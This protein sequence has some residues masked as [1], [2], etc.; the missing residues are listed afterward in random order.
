MTTHLCRSMT[1]LASA[2]SPGT[3]MYFMSA[4]MH[5]VLGYT[6][7]SN[8]NFDLSSYKIAHGDAGI[9]NDSS[10]YEHHLKVTASYSVSD[11]DIGRFVAIKS[12][13]YP[14]YNS[15]LFRV[16]SVDET[17]NTFGLDFKS[18]TSAPREESLNWAL[19]ES[20]LTASLSWRSGSNSEVAQYNSQY[21]TSNAS[22]IILSSPE[23]YSSYHVRFCLE[24][25]TDVSGAVGTAFSIAPGLKGNSQGDYY[26]EQHL[27]GAM[28]FNTTASQYRGTTV[29]LSPGTP[30]NGYSTVGEWE[31]SIVGSDTNGTVFACVK[32]LSMSV[33]GNAWTYFGVADDE[34]S[35]HIQ[36]LTLDEQINR[37]VVLGSSQT[38]PNLTLEFNFWDTGKQNG[39]AWSPTRLRPVSCVGST[40]SHAARTTQIRDLTTAS[41]GA[42]SLATELIDI[43]M[44]AGT[45]D[46]NYDYSST[47]VLDFLPRPMGRMSFVRHGRANFGD[48]TFTSDVSSS[49]MHTSGGLYMLW[50]GPIQSG[51][52]TGS[53]YVDIQT[54]R[55]DG[56][57]IQYLSPVDPGGD[58]EEPRIVV[59]NDQDAVRFRKT[60]SYYRQ[61]PRL[62]ETIEMGSP[63]LPPE[64]S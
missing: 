8:T 40:Y 33:G 48:W 41:T 38:T 45:Y 53:S 63:S 17:N 14:T 58:E 35:T 32:N 25:S 23:P 5:T 54:S 3:Q 21:T 26:K 29:G 24:S 15:G 49:W 44:I 52:L 62:I 4:F 19:Y 11:S 6:V 20:E 57:G 46:T 7:V 1:T 56:Y 18:P 9:F 22:R 13:S 31:T 59:Y 16:I 30:S 37:L 50:G 34:D 47:S 61:E 64:R 36:R 10:G 27:H 39:L 42:F 28:W 12:I 43:E 60:Y 51:S 55:S 2:S